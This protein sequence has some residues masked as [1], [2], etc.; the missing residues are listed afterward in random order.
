MWPA[1]ASILEV[2]ADVM[3]VVTGLAATAIA[4]IVFRHNRRT[5]KETL[6]ERAW[7]A[8]QELNYISLANPEVL[9][10]AEFTIDGE[11]KSDLSDEDLRRAIY[12]TFIQLNRIHL[13]WNGYRSGIFRKTE[14]EDEIRPTLTLISGNRALLDYCLTRGYSKSFVEF[15]TKEADTLSQLYGQPEES[16]VFI[17]NLREKLKTK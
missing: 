14:I 6:R 8:Q 17:G 7:A 2:L 12:A 16:S 10:A 1:D 11:I 15:A 13:L 9:K 3:Q 4:F 5:D